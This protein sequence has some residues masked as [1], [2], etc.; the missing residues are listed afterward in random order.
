MLLRQYVRASGA[1]A[2]AELVQIATGVLNIWI[3]TAVLGIAEYGVYLLA[4][5]L[6]TMPSFFVNSA[7]ERPAYLRLSRLEDFDSSG[8]ALSG[9]ALVGTTVIGLALGLGLWVAAPTLAMAFG[10]ETLSS[11]L[12][13]MALIPV[14]F[15][16]RSTVAS[17]LQAQRRVEV[18]AYGGVALSAVVQSGLYLVIFAVGLGQSAVIAAATLA[19]A[20]AALFLLTRLA[21]RPAN[22]LAV[23]SRADLAYGVQLSGLRFLSHGEARL[24]TWLVAL[25]GSAESI[26]LY[27]VARRLAGALEMGKRALDSMLVP[28]MGRALAAGDAARSKLRSEVRIARVGGFGASLAGLG[29]LAIFSEPILELLGGYQAA[30]PILLILAAAILVETGTGTAGQLVV[31]SGKA[32]ALLL[33]TALSAATF[34]VMSLLIGSILGAEGVALGA[35]MAYT[36]RNSFAVVLAKRYTGVSTLTLSGAMVVALTS[37]AVALAAVADDGSSAIWLVVGVCGLA[38]AATAAEGCREWQ[39][40]P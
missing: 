35:L 15:S 14:A 21:W 22:P 9:A 39:A 1:T 16:I 40:R 31:M 11:W 4:L 30:I 37:G 34:V 10:L 7:I 3:L 25:V 6:A 19:P 13:G 29:L 28:R 2:A 33:P 20:V 5:S 23:F 12:R 27:T 17:C 8:V 26:A 36:L 24:D 32:S 38:A 18:A